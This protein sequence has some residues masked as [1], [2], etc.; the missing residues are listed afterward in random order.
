MRRLILGSPSSNITYSVASQKTKI[1][2]EKD[3]TTFITNLKGQT[4]VETAFSVHQGKTKE[5]LCL[6]FPL[7]YQLQKL[8]GVEGQEGIKITVFWNVALTLRRNYCF[9]L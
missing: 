9:H 5:Q 3:D 8:F 1:L 4:L 2:T 6:L 7:W